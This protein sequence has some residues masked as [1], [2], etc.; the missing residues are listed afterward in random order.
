MLKCGT[1]YTRR[2]M[3]VRGI[4]PKQRLQERGQQVHRVARPAIQRMQVGDQQSSWS[5]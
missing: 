1:T 5:H 3:D 2:T 4:R